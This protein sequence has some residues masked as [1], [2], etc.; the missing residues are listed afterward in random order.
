MK[1]FFVTGKSLHTA[2]FAF[3]D[4]GELIAGFGGTASGPLPIIEF[5][6]TLMG[7]LIPREGKHLRPID[8]GDIITATGAL[9]VAGNGAEISHNP[10][11]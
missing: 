5:V 2:Q 8:A 1:A 6:N 4:S 10:D 7:I 3:V 11:W 9:V